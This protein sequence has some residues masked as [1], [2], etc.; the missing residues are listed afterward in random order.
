MLCS[1]KQRLR[2]LQHLPSWRLL[3][4]GM[5][6][7]LLFPLFALPKWQLEY[8]QDAPNTSLSLQPVLNFY[9]QHGPA[10]MPALAAQLELD[11]LQRYEQQLSAAQADFSDQLRDHGWAGA[12]EFLLTHLAA[13]LE[14]PLLLHKSECR[15]NLCQLRVDAPNGLNPAFQRQILTFASTLKTANL[16]FKQ[17]VPGQGTIL[18]EFQSD[19]KLRFRF[20]QEWQLRSAVP[21]PWQQEIQFWLQQSKAKE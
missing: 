12:T 16:E 11:K 5:A 19:K 20:W 17:L 4:L 2:Y 7:Y 8:W 6:F 1:L 15:N 10:M 9:Q 21:T 13:N 14:Q 3:L 18:L